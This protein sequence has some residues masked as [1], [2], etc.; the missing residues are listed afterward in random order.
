M[1]LLKAAMD[2]LIIELAIESTLT[3]GHI[4]DVNLITKCQN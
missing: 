3:F 1:W 4:N 2:Y